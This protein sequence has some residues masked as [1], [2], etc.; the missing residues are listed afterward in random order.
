MLTKTKELMDE[1]YSGNKRNLLKWI[2][3]L[4]SSHNLSQ[5]D[6]DVRLRQL[7]LIEAY[8]LEQPESESKDTMLRGVNNAK[9]ILLNDMISNQIDMNDGKRYF[10]LWQECDCCHDGDEWVAIWL[11][12]KELKSQ[13]ERKRKEIDSY[14][15]VWKKAYSD[16]TKLYAYEYIPNFGF[17]KMDLEKEIIE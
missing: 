2:G 16:P 10:L 8:I 13:I 17:R 6:Y 14:N 12:K 9:K 3:S 1:M 11:S 4:I 5:P 15:E 7:Y